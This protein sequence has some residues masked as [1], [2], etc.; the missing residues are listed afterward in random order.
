MPPP[1]LA[2]RIPAPADPE[3]VTVPLMFRVSVTELFVFF[4]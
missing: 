3:P 4:V 2:I 1:V